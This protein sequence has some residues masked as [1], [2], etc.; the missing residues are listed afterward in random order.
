MSV[1]SDITIPERIA[2][3]E[4]GHDTKQVGLVTL[5]ALLKETFIGELPE[6]EAS[7]NESADSHRTGCHPASN[8][9]GWR[10][11]DSPECDVVYFSAAKDKTFTKS[12]LTVPVG[13]KERTGERPVCYC[14]GH[15]VASIK[16]ELRTKGRSDA[17]Q[18]IRAKMKS[19]G[20]RCETK[21]PSGSCCLGTVAQAIRMAEEEKTEDGAMTMPTDSANNQG[22]KI[23]K[24][25]T[26]LSAVMASA[27]CWLPL[28]LLAVGVSGAGIAAMLEAYR[29]LFMVITFGFLAA[30]FYYTYRPRKGAFTAGHGCCTK[31]S[32]REDNCCAP[33][34]RRLDM[35]SM[36]KIVLWAVTAMA[37]GFLFFPNY[38]GSLMGTGNADVVMDEM[39]RFRFQVEG[40]TCE[41]CAA[42][43]SQVLRSVPGVSAV[44]VSYDSGEAVVGVQD[45]QKVPTGRIVNA[46]KKAGYDGRLLGS[47]G[48]A[49]TRDFPKP[50]QLAA[51]R[52]DVVDA[53]LRQTVFHI[54]GMGCEGCASTVADVI[55]KVPGITGVEV[56]FPSG[57][58]H[59]QSPACC[60][61]PEEDILSALKRAGFKGTVAPDL[62]KTR[63]SQ[64]RN[65]SKEHE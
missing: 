4:C 3:P 8:G 37:I 29:P 48:V 60:R 33:A 56:D 20:C 50:Q 6:T 44:E 36:N 52:N 5:R 30:A 7:S 41:G 24:L 58:A 54:E 16:Q 14:F 27:C 40:M 2:C 12:Q 62:A 45:S 51:A 19:Q 55:R 63:K 32:A 22:E 26:I 53:P 28:L 18:D 9:L 42:T 38:V 65:N 61:L 46:L 43:V 13:I 15:S 39:D 57:Q 59:V 11:C 35:M 10:F 25:G 64:R 49:E 47:Q 1:D 17:L 23:A 34:T 31:D 21:N